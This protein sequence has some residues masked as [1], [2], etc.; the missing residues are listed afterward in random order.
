MI[1]NTALVLVMEKGK[2]KKEKKQEKEGRTCLTLEFLIFLKQ[3]VN[4]IHTTCTRA[5]IVSK[6]GHERPHP[7][8]FKGVV[9]RHQRL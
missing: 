3:K 5:S 4:F 7:L 9:S 2:E 1:A 8:T 6:A